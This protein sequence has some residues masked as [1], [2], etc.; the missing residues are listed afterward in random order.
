MIIFHFQF[1]PN[2]VEE[3][4]SL[5]SKIFK[6]FNVS[7]EHEI[8]QT[9]VKKGLELVKDRSE[10]HEECHNKLQDYLQIDIQRIFPELINK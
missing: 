2:A 8:Y 7:G 10:C 1:E 5:L 9:T 6:V 3:H 4:F